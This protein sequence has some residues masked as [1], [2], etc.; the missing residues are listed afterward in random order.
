MECF[1]TTMDKDEQI[2]EKEVADSAISGAR[3]VINYFKRR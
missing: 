2:I 1:L 3:L